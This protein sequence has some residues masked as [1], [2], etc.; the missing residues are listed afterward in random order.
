M[1]NEEHAGVCHHIYKLTAAEMGYGGLIVFA[2]MLAHFLFWPHAMRSP[3]P[4]KK[5]SSSSEHWS[6]SPHCIW[7]AY[8]NGSFV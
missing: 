5:A 2:L 6:D 1:E 3:V 4:A 8:W 7:L